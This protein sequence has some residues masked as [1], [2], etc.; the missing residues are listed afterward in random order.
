MGTKLTDEQKD[1][2]VVLKR[3]NLDTEG[4]RL[5]PVLLHGKEGSM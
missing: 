3:V 4:I 1:R 2:R 5:G